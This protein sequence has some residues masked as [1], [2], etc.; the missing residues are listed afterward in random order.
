MFREASFMHSAVELPAAGDMYRRYASLMYFMG[1]VRYTAVQQRLDE[2]GFVLL[3][4]EFL[5]GVGYTRGEVET[6]VSDLAYSRFKPRGKE[7]FAEGTRTIELWQQG[8]DNDAPMRL[9]E[10]LKQW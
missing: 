10:L 6:A 8:H 3:A 2:S 1:A 5:E 4:S 7:A 9:A